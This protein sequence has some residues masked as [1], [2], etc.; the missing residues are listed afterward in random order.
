[1]RNVEAD[2]RVIEASTVWTVLAA[3]D[4]SHLI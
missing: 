3:L 2:A 4:A 1:M